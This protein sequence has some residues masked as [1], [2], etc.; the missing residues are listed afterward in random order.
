MPLGFQLKNAFCPHS[1]THHNNHP[2]H[3]THLTSNLGRNRPNFHVSIDM[4]SQTTHLTAN[5]PLS[6]AKAPQLH[7]PPSTLH[8]KAK[9]A[10]PQNLRASAVLILLS[11]CF[12]PCRR[13]RS[14][15]RETYQREEKCDNS[16]LHS[17]HSTLHSP[18]STL[19]SCYFVRTILLG[20]AAGQSGCS[21]RCRC[22]H[23]SCAAHPCGR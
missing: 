22:H 3:S 10:A 23:K 13:S 11:C 15:I 12:I 21:G 20:Q 5:F 1:A 17:P 7:S 14:W 19:A 16:T 2:P 8:T 4:D 9:T 6:E 18:L